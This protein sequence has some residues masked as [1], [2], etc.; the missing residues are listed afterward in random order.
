MRVVSGVHSFVVTPELFMMAI[1]IAIGASAGRHEPTCSVVEQGG[2]KIP[3]LVVHWND[4]DK[5]GFG[6]AF[7]IG[8]ML[9]L[10]GQPL[11]RLLSWPPDFIIITSCGPNRFC[12]GRVSQDEFGRRRVIESGALVRSSSISDPDL[13]REALDW[14]EKS[15]LILLLP[16]GTIN[17]CALT[18]NDEEKNC[19]VCKGRCPGKNLFP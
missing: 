19:H 2:S 11:S 7:P 4:P 8:E 1:S 15:G 3:C 10:L 14:S 5:L 16:D 18:N 13:I 17:N 12:V 9:E 6:I